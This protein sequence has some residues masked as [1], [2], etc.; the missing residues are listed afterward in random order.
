MVVLVFCQSQVFVIQY[1]IMEPPDETV[2]SP[3]YILSWNM[4]ELTREMNKGMPYG[5]QDF[6]S[7]KMQEVMSDSF[8]GNV[9]AAKLKTG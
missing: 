8:F 7:S 2:C 4:R 1:L 9:T 6:F 3:N 5:W